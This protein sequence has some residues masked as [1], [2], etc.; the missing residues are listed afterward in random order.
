MPKPEYV[1]QHYL[2]A[3]Y[4]KNFS[5]DGK[6]A[7]RK[8]RVYRYDGKKSVA[9]PVETQ[10]AEDYFYCSEARKEVE[11]MFQ[12]MEG[13]YGNL[14]KKIWDWKS[15]SGSAEYFSFILALADFHIRNI[16][17]VNET[18]VRRI[19]AYK[20]MLALWRDFICSVENASDE[21]WANVLQED[22]RVV[23]VAPPTG[24]D[25]ITSDNP[26][27]W[28]GPKGKHS[29]MFL[30]LTPEQ[31]AV[32]YNRKVHRIT[33]GVISKNDLDQLNAAQANHSIKAVYSHLPH[34]PK[35]EARVKQIFDIRKP[36]PGKIGVQGW[37]PNLYGFPQRLSFIAKAKKIP[38]R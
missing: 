32:A 34:S 10:C 25:F 21:K 23:I 3:V 11:G 2:P 8:S 35:G 16:A 26:C 5:V 13:I 30:P 27:I 14:L 28:S 18:G 17:Y 22:W 20:A 19:E 37:V 4:L 7:D 29:L 6:T 12:Q 33:K 9:V 1:W 38:R 24:G 36:K 15:A 31:M